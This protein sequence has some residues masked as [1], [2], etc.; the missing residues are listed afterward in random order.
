MFIYPNE[1]SSS[2]FPSTRPI[3]SLPLFLGSSFPLSSQKYDSLCL[4]SGNQC[5][6]NN[7]KS[8]EIRNQIGWNHAG[9]GGEAKEEK[10]EDFSYPPHVVKKVEGIHLAGYSLT[11]SPRSK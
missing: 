1:T 5:K 6:Q 4:R 11:H 3:L 10:E 7:S 9:E 8:K 2:S